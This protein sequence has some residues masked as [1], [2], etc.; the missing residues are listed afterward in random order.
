MIEFL[1]MEREYRELEAMAGNSLGVS[2]MTEMSSENLDSQDEG[3]VMSGEEMDKLDSDSYLDTVWV[4]TGVTSRRIKEAIK[5]HITRHLDETLTI[6][7][8]TRPSMTRYRKMVH[9]CATTEAKHYVK[10]QDARKGGSSVS[11]AASS[12]SQYK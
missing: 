4:S 8:E 12:N 3:S 9:E 11:M 6:L 10:K 2:P 5:E 7:G 1:G